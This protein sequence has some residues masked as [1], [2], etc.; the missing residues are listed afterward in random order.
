MRH[1]GR[2]VCGGVGVGRSGPGWAGNRERQPAACLGNVTA[3][4]LPSLLGGIKSVMLWLVTVQLSEVCMF[5]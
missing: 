4:L 5:L 2:Q 3:M 1:S